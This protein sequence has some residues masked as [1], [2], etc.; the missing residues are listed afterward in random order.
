VDYLGAHLGPALCIVEVV[1]FV[2]PV[3]R[4]FLVSGLLGGSCGGRVQ[5]RK[6][7]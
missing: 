1:Y 3:F 7:W 6:T 4:T 5:G 2:E